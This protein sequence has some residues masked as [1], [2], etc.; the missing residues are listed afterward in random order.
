MNG[1]GAN[2]MRCIMKNMINILNKILIF[3]IT[4]R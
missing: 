3:I 2:F 4:I 1:K